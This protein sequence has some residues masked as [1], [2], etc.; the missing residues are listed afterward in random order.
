MPPIYSIHSQKQML[1][2]AAKKHLRP[3]E[4]PDLPR[5]AS[6]W[7]WLEISARG[8]GLGEVEGLGEPGVGLGWWALQRQARGLWS[9]RAAL[10][11]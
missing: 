1:R 11:H 6:E 10:A 2:S 8:H 4:V 3:G 7:P 9:H 5:Y